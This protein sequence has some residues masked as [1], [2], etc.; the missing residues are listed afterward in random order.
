M[1]GFSL[2]APWLFKY[3]AS[4]IAAKGIGA[5][6][7]IK[8]DLYAWVK[9]AVPNA[10][11]DAIADKCIDEIIVALQAATQDSGSIVTLMTALSAKDWATAEHELKLLVAECTTNSYLAGMIAAL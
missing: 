11:V 5:L 7:S 8:A 6:G 3:V 10:S 4:E 9:K 1:I 2:I